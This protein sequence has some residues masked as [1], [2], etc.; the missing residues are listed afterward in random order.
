MIE[1][2]IISTKTNITIT[3]SYIDIFTFFTGVVKSLKAFILTTTKTVN[4]I[5]FK[6][7][8]LE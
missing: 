2:K 1:E 4:N 5:L 8:E 7:N 6:E 3:S